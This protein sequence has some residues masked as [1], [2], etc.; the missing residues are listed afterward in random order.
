[1]HSDGAI[2]C[3][4]RA[5]K[6]LTLEATNYVHIFRSSCGTGG[7]IADHMVLLNLQSDAEL[8]RPFGMLFRPNNSDCTLKTQVGMQRGKLEG[9][10]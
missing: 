1:M 8:T 3:T 2:L 4:S 5:N 10:A 7:H 6:L 9:C